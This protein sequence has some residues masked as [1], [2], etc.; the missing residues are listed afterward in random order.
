MIEQPKERLFLPA[1]VRVEGPRKKRLTVINQRQI[2]P[3]ANDAF[4]AA[5]ISAA[6]GY[7]FVEPCRSVA[8]GR[9]Q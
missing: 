5:V 4:G 1:S 8:R 2:G 7:E 6:A 3:H 9:N